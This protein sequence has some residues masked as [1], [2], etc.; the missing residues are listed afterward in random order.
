[1]ERRLDIV[2][3]VSGTPTPGCDAEAFWNSGICIALPDRHPLA[4]C[5]AI[6]WE[7]LKDE[8]F[9][10]GRE[11][12]AAGF[13]GYATERIARNRRPCIA[14]DARSYSRLVMQFIALG[15]GLGLLSDFSTTIPYPGVAFRPLVGEE[16]TSPTARFGFPATT[17]RR[18]GAF[19]VCRARSRRDG[20][21]F[22]GRG[23][24]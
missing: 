4:G 2:F 7:L 20:V 21:N 10:M 18:C 16:I 17:I 6:D 12:T 1:M 5:D 22:G 19:S 8:H 14:H 24:N 15:F 11:A 23:S 3:V 9:V 13:D